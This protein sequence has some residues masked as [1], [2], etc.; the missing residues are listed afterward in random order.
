MQLILL[1]HELKNHKMYVYYKINPP[2]F[3]HMCKLKKAFELLLIEFIIWIKIHVVQLNIIHFDRCD[4]M[5]Y[6]II[7]SLHKFYDMR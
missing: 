5:T 7:S 4:K 2:S 1:A 6:K 3:V